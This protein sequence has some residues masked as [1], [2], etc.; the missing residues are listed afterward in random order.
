MIKDKI[1]A[2]IIT[3]G[4]ELLIGQT[5]DTNSAWMGQQ[6]NNIGI[7]VKRR[8]AVGDVKEEILNALDEEGRQS[9]IIFITGGLGPTADDITKPLLCEYF[10]GKMVVNEEALENVKNIF[11]KYIKKP[12]LESNLKQAE[13]PDVCKV[14]QNKRGSAPG[15]WFEHKDTGKIFISMPGVPNEMK[16]MMADVILQR[17]PTLFTLPAVVHRTVVTAG[18]GESFVAERIKD[19][20]SALPPHIKLAYLPNYGLVKLRLT[21]TGKDK[22]PLTHEVEQLFTTMQSMLQDIIVT[23]EDKTL[24]EVVGSL[25]SQKGKTL[26]TAESCSGGYVA[27]LI[28]GI[29]GAS[30]YFKGS[31]VCYDNSIKEGVLNVRH[32]TI[33]SD[34]AVSEATVRQMAENVKKLMETDFSVAISGIMGPDG[35]TEEKPVGTVWIAVAGGKETIAQKFNLRYNRTTNIEVTANLALN[36]LRVEIVKQ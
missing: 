18:L 5:I 17:L 20:E 29:A 33:L 1:F 8:V 3:I 30:A 35:G 7:W 26:S 32:E 34:G 16:G 15:M 22:E 12:L 9:D 24:E 13:V 25:L 36:M 31:V 21:A 23:N 19:F 6:L 27:Q 28:T 10:G 11:T 4:D 2:S 14:I